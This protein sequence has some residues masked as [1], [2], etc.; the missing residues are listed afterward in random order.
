MLYVLEYRSKDFFGNLSLKGADKRL[1]SDTDNG[2]GGQD[3]RKEF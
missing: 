3:M 1:Y 2:T